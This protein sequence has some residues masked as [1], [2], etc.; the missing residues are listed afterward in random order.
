MSVQR[1]PPPGKVDANVTDSADPELGRELAA[2]SYGTQGLFL[3]SVPQSARALQETIV[4]R[5]AHS[6]VVYERTADRVQRHLHLHMLFAENA[7]SVRLVGFI[8]PS[9][10]ASK[11]E[12]V[13]AQILVVNGAA[14]SG[15]RIIAIPLFGLKVMISVVVAKLDSP[16]PLLC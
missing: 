14:I 7:E 11:G 15:K 12:T 6:A 3:N 4:L 9:E 10:R 13:L 5:R 16:C 1:F 2:S 8:Y